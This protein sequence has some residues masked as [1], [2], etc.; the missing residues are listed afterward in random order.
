VRIWCYYKD[1]KYDK[2]L[3]SLNTFIID[4][5]ILFI[6]M[7]DIRLENLTI[8]TYTTCI[9]LYFQNFDIQ[10]QFKTKR[11]TRALQSSL[12]TIG[13]IILIISANSV[14]KVYGKYW[15]TLQKVDGF[16]GFF[17]YY[18][19]SVLMNFVHDRSAIMN[20]NVCNTENRFVLGYEYHG[21]TTRY[22]WPNMGIPSTWKFDSRNSFNTILVNKKYWLISL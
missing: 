19:R 13:I 14:N 3:L 4:L 16:N 20:I 7:W 18:N 17:L 12:R 22:T 9:I 8:V 21:A 1:L 6:F 11:F 10:I 15:N 2:C 5:F